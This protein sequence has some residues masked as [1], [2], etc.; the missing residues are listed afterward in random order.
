LWNIFFSPADVF[1]AG[2]RTWLVPLLATM[3]IAAIS[4]AMVVSIVGLETITR[5]QLEGNP[6]MVDQLGPEKI[7]QIA[8]EAGQSQA[9]KMMSYVLPPVAVPI[10]MLVVSG[11]LLGIYLMSGS[12]TNL[13]AVFTATAWSWYAV[14]LIALILSAIVLFSVNDFEGLDFQNLVALNPTMFIEP[15][16]LPKPV[17]TAIASLD[18]LAFY[19]I[20]LL[21]FGVAKLSRGITLGKSLS[22]VIAG[23]LLWVVGKVG[24]SM[25]F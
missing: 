5:A 20:F 13:S 16:S 1:V 25:L 7:D 17:Y 15:D 24:F 22:V 3:I 2:K 6:R 10:A 8:R 9:R 23:W 18:L 21:A 12:A 19:S 14:S 4:S 11:I